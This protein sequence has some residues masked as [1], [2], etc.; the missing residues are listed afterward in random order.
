MSQFVIPAKPRKTGREAGSRRL[1]KRFPDLP[2]AGGDEIK[3][4][5][6]LSTGVEMSACPNNEEQAESERSHPL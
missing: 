2:F 1:L 5:V 6:K 3:T 4:W